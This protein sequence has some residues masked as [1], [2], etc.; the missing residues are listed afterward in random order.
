LFVLEGEV[1]SEIVNYTKT[2]VD[3]LI[4]M[5]SHGSKGLTYSMKGGIPEKVTRYSI[6]Q[7]LCL[8]NEGQHFIK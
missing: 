6:C 5:S 7:A 2:K 4:V 3:D 1:V 8:K